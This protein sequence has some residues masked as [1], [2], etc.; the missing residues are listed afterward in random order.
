MKLQLE[1]QKIQ[2]WYADLLNEVKESFTFKS[3][4][5]R[6]TAEKHQQEKLNEVREKKGETAVSRHL[7][8]L[9]SRDLISMGRSAYVFLSSPLEIRFLFFPDICSLLFLFLPSSR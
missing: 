5:D 2:E 8:S 3:L 7:S 4:Q 9:L 6:V 1:R